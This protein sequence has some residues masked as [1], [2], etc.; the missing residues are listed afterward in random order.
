MC[1]AHRWNRTSDLVAVEA[2]VPMA[3]PA[4]YQLISYN[5]ALLNWWVAVSNGLFRPC[6]PLF[7][8]KKGI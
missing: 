3:A 1:K 7:F 8:L 6:A 5:T 4:S 2:T